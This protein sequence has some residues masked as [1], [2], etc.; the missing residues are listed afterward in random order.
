MVKKLLLAP[1]ARSRFQDGRQW[2]RLRSDPALERRPPQA[3]E[4]RDGEQ[5]VPPDHV[6]EGAGDEAAH[7][8]VAAEIDVRHPGAYDDPV[9]LRAQ[10][11]RVSPPCS[12]VL[13][14]LPKKIQAGIWD[15]KAARG[16]AHCHRGLVEPHISPSAMAGGA[17][18]RRAAGFLPIQ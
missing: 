7:L 9:G 5:H 10:A 17:E 6:Q 15:V 3:R 8:A 1:G 13:M 18:G 12:R 2:T 4:G 16:T 11:E 14:E